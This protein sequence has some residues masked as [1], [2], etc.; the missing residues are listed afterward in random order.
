MPLH[1]SNSLGD[2]TSQMMVI[3]KFLMGFIGRHISQSYSAIFQL[4]LNSTISLYHEKKALK[5]INWQISPN[6][7]YINHII[8][9][10]INIIGLITDLQVAIRGVSARRS[11]CFPPNR[12]AKKG[13]WCWR[14]E[15]RL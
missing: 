15:T 7:H 2:V 13:Q 14:I 5:I 10:R 1:I 12:N 4:C 11:N 6:S 9:G 3:F 8:S